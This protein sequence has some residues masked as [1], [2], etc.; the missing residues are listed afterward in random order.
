MIPDHTPRIRTISDPLDH[1]ERLRSL[2]DQVTH[3][4]EGIFWSETHMLTECYKLVIAAMH[5][6]DKES[7]LH[8]LFF[9]K[10][11]DEYTRLRL[12]LFPVCSSRIP[13]FLK[14]HS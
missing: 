11:R 3:E 4:V 10:P 1:F 14:R 5:I 7:S 12:I 13:S 2:V 8:R 9:R 6:T